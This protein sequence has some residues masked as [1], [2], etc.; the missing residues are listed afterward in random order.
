M[1]WNYI[2]V[3][4]YNTVSEQTAAELCAHFKMVTMVHFMSILK[5]EQKDEDQGKGGEGILTGQEISAELG[6]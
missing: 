1:F 2:D 6:R 4:V 3:M 5:R